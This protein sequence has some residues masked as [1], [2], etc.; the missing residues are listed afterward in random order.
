M[1]EPY[2]KDPLL[3]KWE[4]AVCDETRW[5]LRV[6][7]ETTPATQVLIFFAEQGI[8]RTIHADLKALEKLIL[9]ELSAA[10]RVREKLEHYQVL[11]SGY[12]GDEARG[13]ERCAREILEAFDGE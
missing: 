2:F 10:R 12:V 3:A 9:A 13:I 8:D 6:L 11:A 1:A 5:R 7:K 4:Q